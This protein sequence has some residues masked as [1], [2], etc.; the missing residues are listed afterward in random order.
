[1]FQPVGGGFSKGLIVKLG[2]PIIGGPVSNPFH[3]ACDTNLTS[4]ALALNSADR[5]P[6]GI[7]R[8]FE[9][10][11]GGICA[12]Q[13]YARDHDSNGLAVDFAR[14]FDAPYLIRANNQLPA[15]NST[16]PRSNL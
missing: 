9:S 7:F 3:A 11:T 16:I 8:P 12:Q 5:F 13:G 2:D 15:L 4:R 14:P 10:M 1:M 6:N